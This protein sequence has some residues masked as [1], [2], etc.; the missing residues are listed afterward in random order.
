V[1]DPPALIELVQALS[2]TDDKVDA[3]LDVLPGRILRQ[4]LN[5]PNDNLLDARVHENLLTAAR[6]LDSIP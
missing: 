5:A 4:I 6:L 1:S 3:F 2:H